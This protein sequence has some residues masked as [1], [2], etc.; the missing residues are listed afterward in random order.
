MLENGCQWRRHYSD[1]PH[2]YF[3]PLCAL[4]L[5]IMFRSLV[6]GENRS[7][8]LSSL[9]PNNNPT[10]RPIQERSNI[11]YVQQQGENC[12]CFA[13]ELSNLPFPSHSSTIPKQFRQLGFHQFHSCM[14]Y[15]F[16]YLVHS[17]SYPNWP[18]NAP[19]FVYTFR[20]RIKESTLGNSNYLIPKDQR[21][22]CEMI[23]H[24]SPKTYTYV[25]ASTFAPF[26]FIP[27]IYIA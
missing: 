9:H 27:H 18:H 24:I 5:T 16:I 6:G 2:P 10:L 7:H 20:I 17:S 25:Q 19:T 13:L 21:K 23:S 22:Q 14:T 8:S 3:S 1:D 12:E 15:I 4:Q 11:I 26:Y